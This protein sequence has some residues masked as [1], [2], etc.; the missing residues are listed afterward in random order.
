VP[1][2]VGQCSRLT[3]K[4][5][6]GTGESEPFAGVTSKVTSS[7]AIE[8]VFLLK[9]PKQFARS[10]LCREVALISVGKA[11]YCINGLSV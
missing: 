2:P 8:I 6:A 7:Q 5:T 10:N 11:D 1:V 3:V 4:P 9:G